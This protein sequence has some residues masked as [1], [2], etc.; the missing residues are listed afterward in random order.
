MEFIKQF[1]GIIIGCEIKIFSYNKNLAYAATLSESQIV[2]IGKSFL[3]SFVLTFSTYLYL[4]KTLSRL[5]PDTNNQYGPII[6]NYQY[7]V[8]KL[9]LTSA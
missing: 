5:P 2:M 7:H 3:D 9:F 4:K 8:N 1:R 6:I